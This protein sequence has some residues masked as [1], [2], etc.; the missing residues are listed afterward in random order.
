M[1]NDLLARY[2]SNFLFVQIIFVQVISRYPNFIEK[3]YS[4][5]IYKAISL[6]YRTSLGW[7]PFSVGDI[8]YAGLILLLIRFVYVLFRD[9]LS[10]LRSYRLSVGSTLS[11]LYFF[12]YFGWG[13]NYYRVPLA[14]KLNIEKEGYSTDLLNDFTLKTVEIIN[15][16]HKTVVDND[17]L[18]YVVPYSR[19]EIYKMAKTGYSELG[20]TNKSFKY[21][22]ASVKHSLL[23]TPLTYMG[24]AGYLNPF[25]G[26]AQVNSKIPIYTLAFTTSHEMAHQIG[27]AAENE[28]NFIGYLASTSHTDTYFKL[29]GHVTALKYLLNELHKRD[30]NLYK[31]ALKKINRGILLNMRESNK[32]WSEY[33]NPLEPLFKK[34]YNVYLKAN[35]QKSGIKSYSYMVDLLLHY[36]I[37]FENTSIPY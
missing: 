8:L 13:I 16:L 35:R 14:T 4:N 6:F 29:A 1:K 34:S 5:G 15:E 20:K 31:I 10:E 9:K 21:K 28:A 25:S 2:L 19:R 24:F 23:S 3:Y 27:Y 32:F 33:E 17:S 18:P 22:V 37:K 11:V 7:I 30:E 12:F 26:E 36:D